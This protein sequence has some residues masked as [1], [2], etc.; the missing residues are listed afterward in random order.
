M[1]LADNAA[2]QRVAIGMRAARGE[3]KDHVARHDRAAVDN[4]L[5]LDHAD[6]ESR[7]VVLALGIHAGHFGGLAADQRATGKLATLGDA[8]HHLRSD[9]LVE[10]AAGEIIQEEKRFGALYQH[11]VHAHGH[12]V[13]ADACVPAKREGELQLGA[14]AVGA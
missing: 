5:L 12:E 14:Y 3:A 9:A 6:A 10:L 7:E 8:F 4:A 2:D 11:I 13:H 1:V